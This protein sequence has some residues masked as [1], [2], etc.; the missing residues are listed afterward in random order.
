MIEWLKRR[1][2]TEKVNT[3]FTD[4]VSGE[5]VFRFRDY[6]GQTFLANHNHWFFRLYDKDY[7]WK[8]HYTY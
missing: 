4:M 3:A 2:T 7:L 6:D 5:K 8:L 1:L